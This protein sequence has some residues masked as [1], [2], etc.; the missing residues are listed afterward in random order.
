MQYLRATQAISRT[1]GFVGRGGEGMGLTLRDGSD[2]VHARRDVSDS[3]A[4]M[5]TTTESSVSIVRYGLNPSFP[6]AR[7]HLVVTSVRS[8]YKGS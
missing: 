8:D 7:R 1:E 5:S 4:I 2:I 3:D 6:R